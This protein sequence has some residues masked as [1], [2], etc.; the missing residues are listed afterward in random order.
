MI[1][2]L[3]KLNLAVFVPSMIGSDEAKCGLRYS[4]VL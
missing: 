3:M 1:M 4:Q 2:M